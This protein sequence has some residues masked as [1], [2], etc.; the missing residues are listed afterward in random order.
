MNLRIDPALFDYL[1]C[2]VS[3]LEIAAEGEAC[4]VACNPAALS[5]HGVSR[6]KIVGSAADEALPDPKGPVLGAAHRAVIRSG[7][8]QHCTLPPVGEETPQHSHADLLPQTGADGSVIR[9]FETL[10]THHG[11]E[12]A[13]DARVSFET[14]SSEME[15]YVAIAAHD[16]RAP[17]R[18]I[19]LLADMLRDTLPDSS[20][21]QAELVDLIDSVATKSMDLISDV[22]DHATIRNAGRTETEVDFAPLVRKIGDILDPDGN[23]QF[24]IATAQ[25]E[26]DGPALQTVL[27]NLIDHVLTRSEDAP[28]LLD[29]SVQ[30]GMP[31][32]L[33]FLLSFSGPGLDDDTLKTLNEGALRPGNGYG[34]LGI[35]RLVLGRGGTILARNRVEEGLNL[36]RFSLPGRLQMSEVPAMGGVGRRRSGLPGWMSFRANAG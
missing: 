12:T 29:I 3:V 17:M 14:L 7:K 10:Q 35:R 36:V 9:I 2:P 22:L 5:A 1:T 13:Q 23:H 26:A 27:R 16:L 33:D 18:N 30:Q 19:S 8:A 15:Q 6:E 24:A 34:L 11:V 32:I 25:L 20:P 21:Q 31:G 4:Y 28:L